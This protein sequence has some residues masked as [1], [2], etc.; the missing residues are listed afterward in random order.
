MCSRPTKSDWYECLFTMW[1]D[2]TFKVSGTISQLSKL[3]GCEPHEARASIEEMKECNVANVTE[4]YKIVTLINRRLQRRYKARKTRQNVNG[5]T[6]RKN[7]VTPM[8]TPMGYPLLFLLL[9]LILIPPIPPGKAVPRNA[10]KRRRNSQ[11]RYTISR[12]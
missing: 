8:K 2:K 12:S 3:W 10:V 9:I 7:H 11:H 5:C 4:S 6:G 1:R